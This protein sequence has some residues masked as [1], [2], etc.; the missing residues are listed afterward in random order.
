MK[1]MLAYVLAAGAVSV[2]LSG[3]EK[4]KK[5]AEHPGAAAQQEHP[6]AEHPTAEHPSK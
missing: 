4:Q 5:T 3:C 2:L 1:R 6:T